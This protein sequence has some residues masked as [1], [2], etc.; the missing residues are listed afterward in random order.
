MHCNMMGAK[1]KTAN[2][3]VFPKSKCVFG[4]GGCDGSGAVLRLA[5]SQDAEA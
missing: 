2:A 1:R 4:S 3:T 5:I